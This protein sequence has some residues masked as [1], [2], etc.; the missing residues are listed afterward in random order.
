MFTN[1]KSVVVFAV[2]LI[3]LMVT[4]GIVVSS[5]QGSP[6]NNLGVVNME[7]VFTKYMAPPLLAARDQMQAEFE[8]QAEELE[9]E[10]KVE[11][12]GEYQKELESLEQ[13]YTVDIELAIEEVAKANG[14]TM[15][16]DSGAVLYGG[17]DLTEAVLE[18]LE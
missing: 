3:G 4:A 9:E 1:K 2:L 15:V 5:A 12:F 7:A 6:D 17:V 16:V 8:T 14:V 10:A 18:T 13:Q 11:L